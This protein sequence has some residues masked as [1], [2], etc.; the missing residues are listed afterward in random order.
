MSRKLGEMHS[1]FTLS[2][3]VFLNGGMSSHWKKS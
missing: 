3:F 1:G 2:V